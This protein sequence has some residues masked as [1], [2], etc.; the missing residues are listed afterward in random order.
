MSRRLYAARISLEELDALREHITSTKHCVI[1]L[2]AAHGPHAES[3]TPEAT[4]ELQRVQ[5]H[6]SRLEY[7]I[8]E[9]H[10]RTA[11]GA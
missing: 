3:L 11:N 4:T 9:L 8:Q 7:E 5:G 10:D 2:L 1:G 6:L